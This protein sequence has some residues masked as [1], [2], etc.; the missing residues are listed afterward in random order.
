MRIQL[1]H[2]L[3]DGVEEKDMTM[4]RVWLFRREWL[5]WSAVH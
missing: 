2:M 5:R 1:L 4:L 3:S